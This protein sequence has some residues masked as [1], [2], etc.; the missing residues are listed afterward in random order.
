MQYWEGGATEDTKHLT[1]HVVFDIGTVPSNLQSKMYSFI[2][3]FM[4][5]KSYLFGG[6]FFSFYTYAKS[7]NV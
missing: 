6:F 7:K 2:D 1:V 3:L 5:V 4:F